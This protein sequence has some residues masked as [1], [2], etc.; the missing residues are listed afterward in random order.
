MG[1]EM[2]GK[3]AFVEAAQCSIEDNLNVMLS[4]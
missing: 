1:Q 3:E 2:E 4:L